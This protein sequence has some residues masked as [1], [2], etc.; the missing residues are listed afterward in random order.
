[1]SEDSRATRHNEPEQGFRHAAT[2]PEI[3]ASEP[4]SLAHPPNAK[5]PLDRPL[6]EGSFALAGAIPVRASWLG[7]HRQPTSGRWWVLLLEP[8]AC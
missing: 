4:A 3:C 1:M 8:S 2:N 7:A 6:A 5:H